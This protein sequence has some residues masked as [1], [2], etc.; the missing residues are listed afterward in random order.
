[1]QDQPSTS[2]KGEEPPRPRTVPFDFIWDP[3]AQAW[4]PPGTPSNFDLEAWRRNFEQTLEELRKL[5]PTP[6]EK[7]RVPP[8]TLDVPPAWRKSLGQERD[9]FSEML[10]EDTS[11]PE[12]RRAVEVDP[13]DEASADGDS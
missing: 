8:G 3:E 11:G 13:G 10:D 7:L 5:P 9:L 2:A 12:K 1:M 4:Y 6:P